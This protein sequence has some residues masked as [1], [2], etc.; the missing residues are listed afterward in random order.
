MESRTEV[1]SRATTIA[2]ASA[3]RQRRS[4]VKRFVTNGYLVV[5][6]AV[7]RA[8]R[9]A[10][11]I[12]GPLCVLVGLPASLDVALQVFAAQIRHG[13]LKQVVRHGFRISVHLIIAAVVVIISLCLLLRLAAHTFLTLLG[14]PAG[15]HPEQEAIHEPPATGVLISRDDAT[16]GIRY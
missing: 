5:R 9:H 11:S 1:P 15:W 10:P 13:F 2:P 3:M 7:R 14:R 12:I 16:T 6:R 4:A 8:T